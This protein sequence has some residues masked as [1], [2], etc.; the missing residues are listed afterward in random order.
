MT[1]FIRRVTWLPLLL[2]GAATA[3]GQSPARLEPGRW[4]VGFTHV[5]RADTSRPLPSGRPRPLDI[6]VWYPARTSGGP[7]LTYRRYFLLTPAPQDSLPAAE[8]ARRE[9]DGFSD[10]LVAHG[11]PRASVSAW[12]DAAMLAT[13]DAPPAGGRFP[14][15]LVAQGNGQTLHDQAPLAEYLASYGYV[16]AS[17]P[18]PMRIAGPLTGERE[19]GARAEEQAADLA[20]VLARMAGRPDVA[21]GRLGVVGHSFGARAALLLAM[22]EPRIAALVSLDGGIGT[23]TGRE[24]LASQPSYAPSAMR[25]SI[26]H[27]YERLDPFMAP[28]FALLRS[29]SSADR[30]LV[31]VP[32]MHHHHFA[33][34]GAVSVTEPGLRPALGASDRTA[35]A[36]CAMAAAVR[37]F[38][39]AFLK[40]DTRARARLGSN[41]AWPPL[42]A[43]VHLARRSH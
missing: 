38:L 8:S 23:A 35:S 13:G 29:L 15:V 22:R 12:L 17:V 36:Y 43:P 41:A 14:L 2:V 39:A 42:G 37:D 19:M 24:S 20:F 10:V 27:L 34:L 5:A 11:A 1:R 9:L 26:L 18:S 30:W 4:A 25:G 31:E 28:D 7:R 40:N 32:A 16:V 3:R 6:G 33:S 21:D